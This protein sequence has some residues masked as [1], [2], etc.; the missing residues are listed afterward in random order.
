[1]STVAKCAGVKLEALV[2]GTLQGPTTVFRSGDSKEWVTAAL[3]PAS[4]REL[5]PP[6][7][8]RLA[9]CAAASVVQSLS[10]SGLRDVAVRG[11]TV[12]PLTSSVP[13]ASLD[14]RITT[15]S[16]A[17]GAPLTTFVDVIWL[18]QESKAAIIAVVD[19]AVPGDLNTPDDGLLAEVTD[20]AARRIGAE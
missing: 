12:V 1:M 15:T 8:A 11:L 18:A 3:G 14:L 2:G 5:P 17:F 10:A 13:R 16:V 20:A 4:G 9:I 19:L 7:D 6:R